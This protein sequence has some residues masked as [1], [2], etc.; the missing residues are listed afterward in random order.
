MSGFKAVDL[1]MIGWLGVASSV[2]LSV[3]FCC[4]DQ[5]TRYKYSNL[6]V[7]IW[8]AVFVGS[9]IIFILGMTKEKAK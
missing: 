9:I 8:I 1:E 6:L 7:W 3:I 2:F 5:L 4:V